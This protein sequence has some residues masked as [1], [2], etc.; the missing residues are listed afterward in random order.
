MKK[1]LKT[2][3]I[4][5]LMVASYQS[6]FAQA[7]ATAS[8]AATIITPIAIAKT[9][10]MSFGNVAVQAATGG[11]VIL[12]PT[13]GR[14]TGGAGGVTLP[15]TTGTVTA[16]SFN[17]TGQGAFTYSITLPAD[18]TVIVGDGATHTMAVNTFTSAH[19]TG[20]VD[21]TL[22]A[23]AQTFGV[24]ATLIVSAAQTPNVYT[25]ALGG[26]SGVFTVTVNYN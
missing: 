26:G 21:G 14:S 4:A 5:I 10:D 6:A 17:V 11:T 3:A 9:V 19:T 18:G 15:A 13:S 25:T 20:A 22:V 7:S 12:S 8:V 24:G 2:S 16:A 1:I 23:G